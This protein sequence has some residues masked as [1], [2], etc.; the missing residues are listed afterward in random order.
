M[1]CN[2]SQKRTC[3]RTLKVKR[4][5][6]VQ[7][8]SLPGMAP[9]IVANRLS[10]ALGLRGPSLSVDTACSSAAVA[11]HLGRRALAAGD[12]AR[13][14]VGGVHLLLSPV[15]FVNTCAALMLS[16]DGRS[17]TF[18][19]TANGYA[20]TRTGWDPASLGRLGSW[21]LLTPMLQRPHQ[22]PP[23]FVQ[24]VGCPAPPGVKA[25]APWCWPRRSLRSPL[26]LQRRC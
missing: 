17:K 18:D 26:P 14:V 6:I 7:T 2:K 12:C 11:I 15:N 23:H 21:T 19:A 24:S 22:T 5:R 3:S 9:S 13:A 25:A 8:G 20:R 16:G 10:F 1:R 4:T